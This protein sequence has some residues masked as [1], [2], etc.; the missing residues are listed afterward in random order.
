[1]SEDGEE[2][3][4]LESGPENQQGRLSGADREVRRM[5]CL[6]SQMKKRFQEGGGDQLCNVLLK[7]SMSGDHW[8]R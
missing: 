4:K 8:I 5:L 7:E 3:Q 2:V 1:M 6:G